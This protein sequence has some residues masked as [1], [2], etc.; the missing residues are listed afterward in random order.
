M[1]HPLYSCLTNIG[2][3][4]RPVQQYCN[5]GSDPSLQKYMGQTKLCLPLIT[6][7][8]AIPSFVSNQFNRSFQPKNNVDA[9]AKFTS[10]AFCKQICLSFFKVSTGP[11]S[12]HHN[13]YFIIFSY[14]LTSIILSLIKPYQWERSA[15]QTELWFMIVDDFQLYL[16]KSV[17]LKSSQFW[18]PIHL[19]PLG[20]TLRINLPS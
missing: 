20:C 13:K 17:K 12:S 7:L 8:L 11:G 2:S 15:N 14:P 19:Y 3:Y 4:S 16:L 10:E 9:I 18:L 1:N 5:W 6:N